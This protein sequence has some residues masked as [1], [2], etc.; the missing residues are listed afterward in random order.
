MVNLILAYGFY[1]SSGIKGPIELLYK[2]NLPSIT[3][4]EL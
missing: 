1:I 4:I 3:K 2:F